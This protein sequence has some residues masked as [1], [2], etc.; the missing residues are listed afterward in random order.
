MS[1]LVL[2]LN[3]NFEPL[4]VCDTHRALNLIVAG[5]AR[6]LANGRGYVRTVRLSFPRPSVIQLEKMIH[7]PHPR[8]RL[9]K[10]EVFRRDE[11]TCQYCGRQ[12]AHMTVDHV[13]PRH[14]GGSH[15]WDNLVAACPSCNRRKG[16]RTSDEA[17]MRLLRA[18][19]EPSATA[20]YLFGRHLHENQ[21]WGTFLQGW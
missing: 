1:E 19:R 12:M 8:V 4:H 2:V 3:A 5:K 15:S 7:R 20:V 14:R 21:D 9:S 18:P 10:R 11:F 16:G 13:I 17:H 6:M